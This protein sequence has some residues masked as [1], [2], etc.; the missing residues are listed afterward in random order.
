MKKTE[1]VNTT[2]RGNDKIVDILSEEK[3]AR[4]EEKNQKK[5]HP[6][7]LKLIIKFQYEEDH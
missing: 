5:L 6:S 4:A 7:K 1:V 3:N 2:Q